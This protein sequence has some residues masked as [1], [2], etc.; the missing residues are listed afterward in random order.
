MRLLYLGSVLA[1]FFLGMAIEKRL[2][3][4]GD[5]AALAGIE[6]LHRLDE[7]VTLLNS[8]DA[9]QQ[10][11][12]DDAV[13]LTPDG[14]V[15]VGKAAIYATD[16]RTWKVAPGFSITSYQHDIK[17]VRVLNDDWAVEWGLFEG[18]FHLAT[19]K[20]A[21]VFRGKSLR[22]LRR[23]A[24]GEWKFSHVMVLID[25]DQPATPAPQK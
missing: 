4:A 16:Q 15:D 22:I 14:P 1:S 13:R 9:L 12:T 11:W 6:K 18:G 23:Q 25:S 17:N 7:R 19:D 24:S 3:T 5:S 10:L 20:P 21:D 2:Q 8:P